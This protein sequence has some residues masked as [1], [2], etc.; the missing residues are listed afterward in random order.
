MNFIILMIFLAMA[1]AMLLWPHVMRRS[2]TTSNVAQA[3]ERAAERA[4]ANA[5]ADTQPAHD[6]YG[7][8]LELTSAM[9]ATEIDERAMGHGDLT[10][11]QKNIIN[12]I[13][14]GFPATIEKERKNINGS[15]PLHVSG[16]PSS[17]CAFSPD[18]KVDPLDEKDIWGSRP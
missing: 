14:D 12:L 16:T 6:P 8:S 15:S 18:N 17:Y 9:T 2:I 11:E 5:Y 4:R 1:V 13:F 3:K 10:D 7:S